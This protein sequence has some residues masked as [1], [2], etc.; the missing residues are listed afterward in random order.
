MTNQ[1][2]LSVVVRLTGLEQEIGCPCYCFTPKCEATL[3]DQARSGDEQ[4]AALLVEMYQWMAVVAFR[5]YAPFLPWIKR[6]DRSFTETWLWTEIH[7]AYV[8]AMLRK[9]GPADRFVDALERSLFEG[10][11]IVTSVLRYDRAQL[12]LD[13]KLLAVTQLMRVE[14]LSKPLGPDRDTVLEERLSAEE[15]HAVPTAHD[16]VLGA[17]DAATFA[18]EAGHVLEQHVAS[19]RLAL[20]VFE[21]YCAVGYD[22]EEARKQLVPGRMGRTRFDQKWKKVLRVL[23]KQMAGHQAFLE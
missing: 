16:Q 5:S 10:L 23:K 11:G 1:D 6:R 22:I 20:L 15:T 3:W 21:T 17:R 18:A 7:E 12:F 4:A 2:H 8:A 14:S 19:D 13:K 9:R